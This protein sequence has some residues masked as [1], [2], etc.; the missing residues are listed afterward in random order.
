MNI[1]IRPMPTRVTADWMA[2]Q[3]RDGRRSRRKIGTYPSMSLRDAR[4]VYERDFADSIQKGR[5]IKVVGDTS[6]I[7]ARSLSAPSKT[8]APNASALPSSRS[9]RPCSIRSRNWTPGTGGISSPA[10]TPRSL[11]AVVRSL[12]DEPANRVRLANRTSFP[13]SSP[14]PALQKRVRCAVRALHKGG[15]ATEQD[16]RRART[17]PSG[18]S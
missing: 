8:G 18:G 3:W 5:S 14:A 13:S 12:A 17:R 6:A 10:M 11:A 15:R 7:A 4:E 2:Q 16:R 1:V 9:A